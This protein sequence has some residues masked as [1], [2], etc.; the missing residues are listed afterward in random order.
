[1]NAGWHDIW[2]QRPACRVSLFKLIIT[3]AWTRWREKWRK[4]SPEIHLIKNKHICS[5]IFFVVWNQFFIVLPVEVITLR[6]SE[7]CHSI[8]SIFAIQR[9]SG[10]MAPSLHV[11]IS[12]SQCFVDIHRVFGWCVCLFL[13]VHASAHDWPAHAADLGSSLPSSSSSGKHC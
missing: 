12:D 3:Y 10:V 4:I 13:F 8:T 6:Y 9:R 7:H 1:M 2:S 5:V 11:A